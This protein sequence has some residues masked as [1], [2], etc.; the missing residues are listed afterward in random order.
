MIEELFTTPGEVLTAH[1]AGQREGLMLGILASAAAYYLVKA[2][3]RRLPV[4]TIEE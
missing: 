2:Y 4:K 1:R 3:G